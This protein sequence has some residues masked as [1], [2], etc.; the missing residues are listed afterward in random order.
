MKTHLQLM[1]EALGYETRSYSGRGMFGKSCLGVDLDEGVTLCEVF[2]RII[3]LITEPYQFGDEFTPDDIE[4]CGK[5]I[6]GGRTDNMGLGTILY[7]PEVSYFD[8]DE[9]EEDLEE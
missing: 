1:F 2:G 5:L 7:F 8:E 3:S 6:I 4:L 9:D